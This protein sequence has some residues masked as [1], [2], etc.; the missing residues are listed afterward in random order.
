[1]TL[2]IKNERF[3]IALTTAF[4][5]LAAAAGTAVGTAQASPTGEANSIRPAQSPTTPVL[6]E[7]GAA[8]K[9]PPDCPKLYFC[10]YKDANF[11]HLAFR[12][13][14]CYMQEIPDGLN[15]GGSWYN[16]Q[17]DHYGALMFNKRKEVIFVVDGAPSW[18]THADW[19]PVWYVQPC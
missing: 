2:R 5:S 6:T 4:L 12:F 15:S 19:H 1:M 9:P 18:D 14:D 11:R 10:G 3:A 8:L 17:S 7:Q 16:N 13:K